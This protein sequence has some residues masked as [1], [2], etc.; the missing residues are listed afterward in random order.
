MLLTGIYI[1]LPTVRIEVAQACSGFRSLVA[2]GAT[3]VLLS[4]MTQK[5]WAYRILL[6]AAVVPIAILSNSL[7]VTWIIVMGIRDP[8]FFDT[9]LHPASGWVVFVLATAL[10]LALATFLSRR[11]ERA[12]PKRRNARPGLSLTGNVRPERHALRVPR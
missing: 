10:L 7:R 8:R 3:G 1:D 4:Y 6:V 11:A 2:L 12:S 9:A 5:R